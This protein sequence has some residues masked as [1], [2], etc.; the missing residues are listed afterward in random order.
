MLSIMF[1]LKSLIAK[2]TTLKIFGE[3]VR[4]NYIASLEQ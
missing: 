4:V 2:K 3:Y 1:L